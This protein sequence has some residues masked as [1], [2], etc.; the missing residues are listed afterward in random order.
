MFL[1]QH[2]GDLASV[3]GVLL[4]LASFGAALWARFTAKSAKEAAQEARTAVTRTLRTVDMQRAIAD[5]RRLAETIRDG[6]YEIAAEVVLSL[7]LVLNDLEGP[8]YSVFDS[9]QRRLVGQLRKQV[10]FVQGNIE[11][12]IAGEQDARPQSDTVIDVQGIMQGL[13]Q[14]STVL[15][16]S[17]V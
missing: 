6:K 2:W 13:M 16:S 8:A 7:L 9:R 12:H 4:A 10:Q 5:A 11:K 17:E 3:A 15:Q 14:L 1:Q